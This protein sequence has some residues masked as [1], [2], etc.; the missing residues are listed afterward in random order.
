[1]NDHD[2]PDDRLELLRLRARI[3][4]VEHSA[5]A[6]LE[7]ALRIRPEEL[8]NALEAARKYLADAYEDKTFRLI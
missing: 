5:L 3:V 2:L 6:A 8:G 7:L 4:S 1:M